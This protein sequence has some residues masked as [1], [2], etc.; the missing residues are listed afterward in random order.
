MFWKRRTPGWHIE[1]SRVTFGSVVENR[2][3]NLSRSHVRVKYHRDPETRFVPLATFIQRC[4][5]GMQG[6]RS[7]GIEHLLVAPVIKQ[8]YARFFDLLTDWGP[9]VRRAYRSPH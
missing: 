6:G 7:L 9:A 8:R 4:R 3:R 5:D 2:V 1:P